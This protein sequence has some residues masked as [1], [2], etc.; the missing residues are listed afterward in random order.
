MDKPTC[1][2]SVWYAGYHTFPCTN[3]GK[4]QRDGKWYCGIHDPV[5][6]EARRAERVAKEKA[7]FRARQERAARQDAERRER[8]R[9][10]DLFPE[11]VA[12]L[13]T[14]SAFGPQN[15]SGWTWQGLMLAP[16]NAPNSWTRDCAIKMRD[17][18]A[19]AKEGQANE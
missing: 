11:L 16:N 3:P 17:V 18:L 8:N 19:K 6:L 10:A 5:R 1:S 14:V 13:E 9:R 2:K 12:T 15:A 4:V 7:E